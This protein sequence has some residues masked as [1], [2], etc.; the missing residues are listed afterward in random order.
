[1][2]T[3]ASDR[4]W[5]RVAL[6]WL[7]FAAILVAYAVLHELSDRLAP[8]AHVQPQLG[9][10]EW[11]FGGTAPT[12]RLQRELWHHDDPHWW[13]YAAWIV[14]LS[15]F[16]VTPAIAL[17]LWLRDYVGF[18]KYRVLVVTAAFAGFFTYVVYPAIP[19]WLASSRGDMAHTE[20]VVR[21]IWDHLGAP[22]IAALFGEGS[23]LA[24]PVGALP[25]LHAAAPFMVMLFFWNRARR[26]RPVLVGYTLAM[27]ITLVY[28]GDHFVFDV[29][30][31]WTYAT[32]VYVVASLFWRQK[33]AVEARC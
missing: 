13:D 24:F 2:A 4:G 33:R 29:L 10:D 1:M 25:S 19:P 32:A 3:G 14:Y 6:D 22:G 20:R 30:L 18:R 31:G 15:H 26:W 5:V 11:L 28:T 9:V 23:D 7:P 12:I 17:G 8:G 16:V 27:A 21:A